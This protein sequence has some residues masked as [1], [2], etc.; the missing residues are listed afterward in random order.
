[1]TT[2]TV[3]RHA[4]PPLVGVCGVVPDHASEAFEQNLD[5]LEAI[6][7]LV[8]RFDPHRQPGAAAHFQ[9]VAEP[10]AQEGDR[11]L[12]L[13]LVDGAIVSSGVYPTRTQLARLVGQH[14]SQTDLA[15]VR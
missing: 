10:L 1:M 3:F 15:A 7:F 11:C 14:R 2:V 5:W 13:I 8:E 4:P 12:P 9:S 6:G